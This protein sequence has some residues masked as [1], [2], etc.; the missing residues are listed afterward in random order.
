MKLLAANDLRCTIDQDGSVRIGLGSH[1]DW[2]GRGRCNVEIQVGDA[3][4]IEDHL[5]SAT[6]IT[7]SSDRVACSVRAYRNRP[8][9]VFRIEA[10]RDLDNLATGAFDQPCVAWPNF[11]PGD[12]TGLGAPSGLRAIAYQHCEFGLPA[13]SDASFDGFFLLPHRPPTGWPIV[14]QAPGGQAIVIAPLNGFHDQTIGLNG[15]TLRCGWHG[16]LERVPKSFVTELGMFAA[17]D[18]RA[19]LDDWGT[20]LREQAGTT[21]PGRWADAL[22]TRPSYWTDNGA[23]YW[24]RT[25]PDTSVADSIVA[26]VDDLRANDVHV[27]AVQ[28]DSWFYP[29]AELRPFNTDE[30]VVPPTAMTAWEPRD[31]VLPEGILSLRKRLGDPPLVAHIRHLSA[32]APITRDVPVWVDGDYAVPA[33]AQGYECWLDQCVSWGVATFEHDWLVEVFFGVRALRAEPGRADAWQVGIDAAARERGITLQ[34]CMAT[35]ADFAQATRLGQVTSVRTCGDH[36]YIATPGQLWAWFC[37]T[38]VLARSLGLAPFK[39]VF[40]TDEQVAGET[41]EIEALLSA[42]STGPVGVGDR[43]GRC[44]IELV[45]ATCRGD[46]ILIKPDVPVATTAES[47]VTNPAFHPSLLVAECFTDHP[48]GRWSYI[49]AA[50]ANPGDD[51]IAGQ[52]V[53]GDLGASAPRDDVIVYDW[54]DRTMQRLRRD[55]S[56]DVALGREEWRYFVAAPVLVGEFAVLGDLTKFV[57]AGD[58]RIEVN[59][60]PTGVNVIVKGAGETV[61][62]SGWAMSAPSSPDG[63]VRFDAAAQHWELDVTVGERGWKS[64][65]LEP[66]WTP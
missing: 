66:D 42:L 26:A 5:G 12:R 63:D 38:N 2:F 24:Y 28:L 27:G 25:E 65:R 61:T 46:G 16:D 17:P 59:T 62:I 20:L 49:V 6:S 8:L 1:D 3:A 13:T 57:A 52:I 23:A 44:A 40:R 54:R 55:A 60:T 45:H 22:A 9:I 31:D 48:A 32:H 21:R 58:A 41:G 47:M 18:G 53:L 33:T 36:G 64:V 50:H 29:H 43:V 14:C 37:T 15:G 7:V 35:P 19:G 51:N 10:L 4:D 11:E 30:W 56:I 39:D 34:W